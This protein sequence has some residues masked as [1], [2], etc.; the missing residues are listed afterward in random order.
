MIYS[1]DRTTRALFLGFVYIIIPFILYYSY[2]Y[3]IQKIHLRELRIK[4]DRV[5]Y[6]VVNSN[7][8][9][10]QK[11]ISLLTSCRTELMNILD[12]DASQ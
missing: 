10:P 11:M 4:F 5:V 7:S 6:I 2:S 9:D 8:K 1:E 12:Q 3:Y